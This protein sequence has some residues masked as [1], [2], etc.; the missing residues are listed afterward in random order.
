MAP[1]D[2]RLRLGDTSVDRLA[3]EPGTQLW[4]DAVGAERVAAVLYLEKRPLIGRLSR[5]RMPIFSVCGSD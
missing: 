3:P 4:N 5:S 2:Q 1:I